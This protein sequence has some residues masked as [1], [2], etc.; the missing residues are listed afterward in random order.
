MISAFV[1]VIT[2]TI[3]LG[4]EQKTFRMSFPKESEAECMTDAEKFEVPLPF[5]TIQAECQPQLAPSPN[6]DDD[7]LKTQST[8]VD[9]ALLISWADLWV[10]RYVAI[11]P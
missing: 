4:S 3:G 5:V 2:I 8:W 11:L 9:D 1:L 10:E 7:I 6:K